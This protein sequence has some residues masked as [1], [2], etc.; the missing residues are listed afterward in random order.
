MRL[1]LQLFICVMMFWGFA[2][3]GPLISIER[4]KETESNGVI[5]LVDPP[6]DRL[7][8]NPGK[9][10][11]WLADRKYQIK[12][13]GDEYHISRKDALVGKFYNHG[14]PTSVPHGSYAL[15][16]V[17]VTFA[18]IGKVLYITIDGVGRAAFEV[19]GHGNLRAVDKQHY[20]Q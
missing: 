20:R 17:D 2:G 11:A 1:Y 14:L 4:S 18:V 16:I 3:C 13:V 15:A 19:D 8:F 12:K 6:P 9:V 10:K 5:I 7:T